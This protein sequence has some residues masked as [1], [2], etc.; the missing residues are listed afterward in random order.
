[1]FLLVSRSSVKVTAVNNE[2]LFLLNVVIA[3]FYKNILFYRI[4]DLL[5]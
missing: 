2:K 5:F 3:L 1:M 4:V